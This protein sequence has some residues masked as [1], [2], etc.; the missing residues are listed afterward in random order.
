MLK[1]NDLS[2]YSKLLFIIAIILLVPLL[3]IPFYN[4]EIIYL[5]SF[6]VPSIFSLF[7]SFLFSL[8]DIKKYEKSNKES[9]SSLVLIIWLWGIIAGAMPFW[10]AKKLDLVQSIF[11]A[12]SAFTTTGL[13]V[14]DVEK[15]SEIFLFH[16]SFM[17]FCGGLGFVMLMLILTTNKQSMDLYSAEGHSDKLVPNLKK[18]A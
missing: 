4:E 1:I 7:L 8:L 5:K 15:T 12:V 10:L 9:S 17:Q 16:R 18:T 2:N 3:V 11:E 13:S 6:L 14:I